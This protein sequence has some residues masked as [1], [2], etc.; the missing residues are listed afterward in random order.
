M[1]FTANKKKERL[2]FK[3]IMKNILIKGARLVCPKNNID[4][5]TDIL[6]KNGKISDISDNI[7]STGCDI[8]NAAGLIATPGLIDIHVHFREP[9]GEHKE[10]LYSGAMAAAKGG[11][12]TVCAMPNT[13]PTIDSAKWVAYIKNKSKQYSLTDV[14]PI[15]AIT[16]GLKGEAIAPIHDM[17]KAGAIAISD[18]GYTVNNAALMLQG[19]KTAKTTGLPVF[20]HCEDKL[21]SANGVIGYGKR[22]CEL[23]LPSID[24]CAEDVIIARDIVL[25]E[26]TG[27]PLHIC[28]IATRGG[29]QLLR[30]AKARGINV[31]G[32]AAPHHFTLS[33]EDIPGDN[34][35]YKMSPPLR[36]PADVAA[37]MQGIKDNTI[38]IIATDHAPHHADEKALGF[39]KAPNGIVGLETSFAISFT[40]LVEKGVITL[41]QLIKKMTQTPAKI[42]NS[43]KGQVSI[44]AC[45]DITI[46]DPHIEYTINP[47]E[48]V[49]KSKNSP[50]TGK[51]VKGK[52]MYTIFE[53]KLV[54]RA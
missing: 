2:S 51:K 18:D 37:V 35:N 24:P 43:K 42:I 27:T 11:F 15:A 25:A 14:L 40:E 20:V 5:V 46:I 31:T 3:K 16:L 33:Y 47:N 48:F 13:S 53:G 29:V 52:V 38:D 17:A 12:T 54:Y 10:D 19:L 23:N 21:L 50:F 1:L 39:L 45:A 34:A 26:A 7:D 49:S 22:S 30:E 28:H 8:I 9:G 44:G 6:I 36:S 32:E 41:N 4:T